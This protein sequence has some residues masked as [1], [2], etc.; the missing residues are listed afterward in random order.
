ML[1]TRHFT[2]IA[3]LKKNKWCLKTKSIVSCD[4]SIGEFSV[5]SSSH[6]SSSM[7]VHSYGSLLETQDVKEDVEFDPLYVEE[8][9]V[10]FLLHMMKK[11]FYNGMMS[12]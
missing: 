6:D 5:A 2:R 3:R 8:P 11:A 9:L 12:S 10:F 7:N 4:A 1:G